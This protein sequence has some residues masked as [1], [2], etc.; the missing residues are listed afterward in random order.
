MKEYEIKRGLLTSKLKEQ[1]KKKK[2]TTKSMKQTK[3]QRETVVNKIKN[4]FSLEEAVHLCSEM[5]PDIRTVLNII[6]ICPA[7][8]VVGERGF[9]LVNLIMNELRS[10]MNIRTLGVA[11]R[12]Y[13]NGADLSDQEADKIILK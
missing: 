10:S 4:Y 8:G 12:I 5:F 1:G 6:A 2:C 11:M 13:Y 9:S 7:S 3:D